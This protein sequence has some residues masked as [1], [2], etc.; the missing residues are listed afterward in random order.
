MYGVTF[1]DNKEPAFAGLKMFQASAACLNFATAKYF[2]AQTK[3]YI[4]GVVLILS[5]TGLTVLEVKRRR[6][7]KKENVAIAKTDGKFDK[8]VCEL[9]PGAKK[10]NGP[11]PV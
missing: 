8:D 6:E 4:V 5:M 1:K 11:T 9:P 10:N 3:I 2:C 7:E